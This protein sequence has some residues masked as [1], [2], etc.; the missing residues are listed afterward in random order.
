MASEKAPYIFVAQMDVEPDKEETFNR[1]YDE[2]HV[3][4][5]LKVPGV[6]TCYR[7]ALVNSSNDQTPRYLAV[8]ELDSPEVKESPEWKAALEVG[9]WI[10]DVRPY[11]LNRQHG[12][13][14]KLG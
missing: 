13:F 7:Y 9:D 4:S 2:E 12:M 14:R 3:P 10:R 6:R 1:I 8:Y 5:L 11:T